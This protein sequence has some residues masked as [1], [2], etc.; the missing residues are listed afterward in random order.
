MKRIISIPAYLLISV[1]LLN[2]SSCQ[3]DR[4][5]LLTDGVWKFENITTNS[6]NETIKTIVAGF[7]AVYTDGTMQFFS[8]GTYIKEYPLID[9]ETGNWEL[10]GETQLVFT[11]DGGLVQTASIDK[12]SKSELVYLETFIEGDQNTFTTVTTWVK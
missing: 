2:L 3:K 8:D 7:K 12:I 1:L 11:P 6:A 9:D 10:V 4:V 5:T